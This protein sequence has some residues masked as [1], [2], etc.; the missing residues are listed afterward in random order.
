MTIPHDQLRGLIDH[1]RWFGGKGREWTLAGVRR[2]GELPDAPDGLHV[3]IDLA[4]IA[5][6]DGTTDYYQLPLALYAEPQDRL[7]HAFV[8]E[9]DDE[10]HGHAFVY[11]ALHD[12]ESMG[13]WLRAFAVAEGANSP[14]LLAFH[15]L[16]GHEFDLGAH[17][18]L[19]SGEQSNSSVAFGEDSLMKVFRKVTPGVNPD[20]AIHQ[21]LTEAG[22]SHVAALYG[23]LD[24]VD[25]EVGGTYSTIQLAM[26]Q[27]FLRTA[28]D[29]WDLAL[30]SVRN[31]FAEADLHADEVGGDFAGEAARLGVALAEVHADLAEH[32]PVERRDGAA[33]DALAGAMEGRLDAALDVVPDLAPY[34]GGL[35]ETFG[36][37]RELDGIDV[38]QVHGDLHLGQ[39]LRTVKGWKI[40][41]FEGEPAKPL[42]ERLLPDSAWRDVAGMI[43]S[44]DYAP[45]VVAMTGG[46]SLNQQRDIDAE[47]DQRAYRASEWAA[48]N[49]AAFLDAYTTHRGQDLDSTASTLLEAY[50]ADK[51]VYEAVYEARNRPGWLSIPLAAL[52]DTS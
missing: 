6:D 25:D 22:S 5:Y 44:F 47:S 48:R 33:L 41:D 35:R 51:V 27:Q 38:Q 16:P 8:G 12:R 52:G 26:L 40:V 30:A 46:A 43:R 21:V 29:G 34:A 4:E 18:T 24:L 31:L 2:V 20:I 42:A 14:G 15:R 17:S 37:L 10:D 1:A 9:W 49:R 7:S 3:A 28:S 39:T 36:R 13:L 23:W 45:R 19:F 11:D 32:F 50:L